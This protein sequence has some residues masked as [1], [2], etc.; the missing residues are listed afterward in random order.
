MRLNTIMG[1]L[2]YLVPQVDAMCERVSAADEAVV[3]EFLRNTTCV[4]LLPVPHPIISRK[5]SPNYFTA[6]WFTSFMWAVVF[7]HNQELPIFDGAKV[8]LFTVTF[9]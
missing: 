3:I 7:Q 5:F 8:K 2:R 6:L 9:A 1:L 4:G